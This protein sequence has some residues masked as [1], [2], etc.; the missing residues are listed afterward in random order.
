M[1]KHLKYI[2]LLLL[3]NVIS[4]YS[5]FYNGSNLTFGKN[6]V[7]YQKHNWVFYRGDR[8]DVYFYPQGKLIAQYVLKY[9]EEEIDI[10]ERHFGIALENKI[11]FLIFVNFSDF[12][13]SNIGLLSDEANNVG[14]QTNIISNKVILYFDRG[15]QEF[16][17]SIK[18]GIASLF[19]N[20]LIN[21]SSYLSQ[22]RTST[23]SNIPSWFQNRCEHPH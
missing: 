19:I 22:M 16:N 10:L 8:C 15:Y 4:S 17:N 1:K 23:L 3:L 14:G 7:Q 5:Q 13:E 6:R 12:K 18:S 11:Q 9:A 2:F 20:E 21:G